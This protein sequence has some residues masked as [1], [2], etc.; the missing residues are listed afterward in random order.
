[1]SVNL[2]ET[3]QCYIREDCEPRQTALLLYWHARKTVHEKHYTCDEWY[4]HITEQSGKF[5][6]FVVHFTTLFSN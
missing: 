2:Y 6:C 3:T 1:M 5:V 4:G